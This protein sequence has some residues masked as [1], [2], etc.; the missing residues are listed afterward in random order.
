MPAKGR[1]KEQAIRQE[2]NWACV[3]LPPDC[4][5]MMAWRLATTLRFLLLADEPGLQ[6]NPMR[7]QG[8]Q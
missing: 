4:H 3:A 5:A 7:K 6:W 1:A 8:W 2:R